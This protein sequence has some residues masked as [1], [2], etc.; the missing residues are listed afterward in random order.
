VTTPPNLG[1]DSDTDEL[2][3][4]IRSQ[5][6]SWESGPRLIV[7]DTLSRSTEDWNESSS[8][9]VMRFVKQVEKIVDAFKAVVMPVH[10]CGKDES[11][12]MRGSSALHGSA[13]AEWM[14]SRSTET[15]PRLLSVEKMKDGPDKGRLR[16]EL[17]D[18]PLGRDEAGEEIVTCFAKILE[19]PAETTPEPAKLREGRF[20]QE[21]MLVAILRTIA[22]TEGQP[23]PN[24]STLSAGRIVA[25]ARF[26]EA[27]ASARVFASVDADS[28]RNSFN[29]AV[30]TL[31]SKGLVAE[32]DELL[33]LLEPSPAEPNA[34]EP[35]TGRE[36]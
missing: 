8:Q 24:G 17:V 35:P 22:K 3:R 6:A 11:K 2:I 12:G 36:L 13:D 26:K 10:H 27:V 5:T 16:Y 31:K 23:V 29:R 30:R 20:T 34:K 33:C 18:V 1:K 15:G 4:Q 7:I 28:A 25:K 21:D 9:D 14:V 19:G 32:E